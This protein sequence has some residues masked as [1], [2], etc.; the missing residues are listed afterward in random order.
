MPGQG[1]VCGDVQLRADSNVCGVCGDPLG[2]AQNRFCGRGCAGKS[3]SQKVSA[4]VEVTCANPHCPNPKDLLLRRRDK[5]V[6]PGRS[7]AYHTGCKPVGGVQRQNRREAYCADCGVAMGQRPESWFAKGCRWC[8]RCAVKNKRRRQPTTVETRSCDS[9]GTEISR[10]DYVI[11]GANKSFCTEDCRRRWLSRP[12]ARPAMCRLCG[13]TTLNGNRTRFASFEAES[14]TYVCGQCYRK[15]SPISECQADG[16]KETFRVWP[17]HPR[18]FCSRSCATK[19]R[20]VRRQRVTCQNPRCTKGVG[21]GPRVRELIPSIAGRQRFCSRSC[22]VECSRRQAKCEV[23]GKPVLSRR[24]FCS[25]KHSTTARK[26]AR[27]GQ[28]PEPDQRVIAAWDSGIRGAHHLRRATKTSLSTVYR[29]MD[30]V[31]RTPGSDACG[32][33]GEAWCPKGV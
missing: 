14:F 17:S 32:G 6:K 33:C 28:I 23:C 31:G 10:P 5:L 1:Q 11:R 20:R 15:P 12:Q 13:R 21:G 16:C 24:R 18:K 4:W 8:P 7:R 30:R 19:S 2:P 25:I 22:A 9:C 26:M 3:K 27:D 29:S